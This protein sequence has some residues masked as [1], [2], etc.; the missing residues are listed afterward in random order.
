MDSKLNLGVGA[1]KFDIGSRKEFGC[2]N[3]ILSILDAFLFSSNGVAEVELAEKKTEMPVK[4]PFKCS[5]SQAG[6]K[7]VRR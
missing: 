6:E 5:S 4:C 1:S 2:R 7:C 3:L